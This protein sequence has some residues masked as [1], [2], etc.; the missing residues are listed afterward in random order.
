MNIVHLFRLLENNLMDVMYLILSL[1]DIDKIIMI[2][3]K[4]F[5]QCGIQQEKSNIMK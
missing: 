1:R 4:S 2:I 3:P 5:N